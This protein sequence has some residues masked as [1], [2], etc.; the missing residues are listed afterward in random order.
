MPHEFLTNRDTRNIF[1]IPEGQLSS[2]AA[3][4]LRSERRSP[5]T[6]RE[7]ARFAAIR[8]AQPRETWVETNGYPNHDTYNTSLI[9]DNDQR[10]YKWLGEWG[11]NFAQKIRSGRFSQDDAEFAVWKYIIPAA[12]GKGRARDWVAGPHY[13]YN[14]EGRFVQMGFDDDFVGDPDI[15]RSNVDYGF[16]VQRILE[17]EQERMDFERS[18]GRSGFLGGP[19]PPSPAFTSITGGGSQYRDKK[20]EF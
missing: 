9:L 1:P 5:R 10:S 8:A 11:K 17:Q 16:I 15:D 4:T 2:E 20:D 12:Q 3:S 18:E 6:Q 7:F 19:N 13:D 14:S